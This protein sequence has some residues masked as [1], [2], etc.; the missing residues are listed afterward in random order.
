METR[1]K[2]AGAVLLLQLVAGCHYGDKPLT[3]FG[4]EEFKHYQDAATRIDYPNVHAEAE[5]A[6]ASDEPRRIR[7]RAKDEIWDVTLGEVLQLALSNSQILRASTQFL[8]PTNTLLTN[9][10]LAPSVFDPAIQESDVLFGRRG[11]EAAL[12]DFDAQFTTTMLWTRDELVQNNLFTGGLPPGTTLA[13]EGAAFRSRLQKQMASGG[14]LS[15]S[16]N[17]GYS[18]NNVPNRLFGSAYDGSLRADYRQP[19]LAGSGTEFTRIAGP[20][21]SNIEGISG[22][23]QGVVIARINND[24]SI[25]DFESAVR[26]L[27]KDVE[28][29]YWDLSLAYRAYDAEVVARNSTLRSW[30]EV[31]CKSRVGAAGGGA[32]DEAQARDQYFESE[33]RTESALADI[34]ATEGRLRRLVGLPVNDGRVMRPLDEP[35]SAEFLPDWHLSLAEALTRR[36]E[37]RRQKWMIQSLELQLSAARNLV[38]PRLD[39]V[40]GY[41]VNGFGDHLFGHGDDD[42][43]TPQ[44]FGSAYETLT[45][46]DQTGWDV[47]V[48]FSMPL[49]FRAA[50]SQV[51]N[52]ELRLAKARAALSAQELEISHELSHAFQSLDRWYQTAATNFDRRRA[53]EQRVLASQCAYDAGHSTLDL[54]LRAQLSLAQAEI[55]YFRSLAEYNKAIADYHHRQGTLLERDN[56]YLAEDTWRPQAYT[57]AV[58]RAWAR[59]FGIPNGHLHTEPCEFVVPRGAEATGTV[60]P[61]AGE[62]GAESEPLAEPLDGPVPADGQIAPPPALVPDENR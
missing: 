28:D 3:Y 42:G 47:G 57:E 60:S 56:I 23:G 5:S 61:P 59:S 46:G 32:A 4:R 45:Q 33:A 27:L 29:L 58:R 9:P 6:V 24:I 43:M 54:L 31:E 34:Y 11:V 51:R 20:V 2:I 41:R 25:V 37:L 16:H 53:A 15:L 14:I 62:V 52:I 8:S 18:S 44:G 7:R 19:L 38:R 55:A 36:V 17:W 22:V 30:R 10:E 1:R 48:E 40:T 13:D 49:G 35:S 21:G 26:N 12:S 39:F 50:H